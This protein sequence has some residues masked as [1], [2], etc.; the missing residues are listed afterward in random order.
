MATR[1]YDSLGF[2]VPVEF[3]SVEAGW[4]ADTGWPRADGAFSRR[5]VESEPPS[6]GSRR[7][8]EAHRTGGLRHAPSRRRPSPLKRLVVLSILLMGVVPLAVGPA[9]L[10]DLRAVVARWS[11]ER[12]RRFEVRD[13]PA[14]AVAEVDRAIDWFGEDPDLL[15]LRAGLRLENRDPGGAK[16]DL[17]RAAELAPMAVEPLRIRAIVHASV[18]DADGAVADAELA[19][20]LAGGVDPQSINF[21][22]YVRALVG[23]D[24]ETA[25]DEIGTVIETL[26]DPPP[27]YIDTRGYLL[28]L[29]GRHE[30]AVEDLEAAIDGMRQMRRQTML[31]TGRV[32]RLELARR[33]RSVDHAL[34][35]ILHHRGLALEALG[36]GA[37]A[38]EDFAVAARKG[39]DPGRGIF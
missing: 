18:G 20:E 35:V 16:R 23:R 6:P 21:R 25:L 37:E 26:G 9:L 4:P 38:A 17:C 39:Y 22:S 27:E 36:R 24:L 11:L 2:P 14:R 13:E 7:S 33:L 31:L 29:L 32:D 8:T 1:A 28:H 10:P 15:C 3:D 34:A 12:A 5:S 30:E 19:C